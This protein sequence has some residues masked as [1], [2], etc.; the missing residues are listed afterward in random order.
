MGAVVSRWIILRAGI[1]CGVACLCIKPDSGV[2]WRHR[3]T[4]A[5]D[6]GPVCSNAVSRDIR[7][8]VMA[9]RR[10]VRYCHVRPTMAGWDANERKMCRNR[11]PDK[12]KKRFNDMIIL[13][14]VLSL[15]HS[16]NSANTMSIAS[17]GSDSSG[18]LRNQGVSKVKTDL[19][20][21]GGCS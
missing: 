21:A 9:Q 7:S 15:N 17:I 20:A 6:A 4:F 8:H 14:F 1:R 2:E 19:S 13:P 12:S 5:Y 11:R 16:A 3:N 18:R 10:G